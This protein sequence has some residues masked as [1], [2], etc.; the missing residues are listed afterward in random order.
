[1]KS[2]NLINKKF[3]KL[4]VI[5]LNEERTNKCN[6]MAAYW[7]CVCDCGNT[8]VVR[9]SCLRSGNSKSCGCNKHRLGKNNPNFTG[10]QEIGGRYWKELKKQAVNKRKLIFNISIRYAWNLFLK[11]NRKCALTDMELKFPLR[12]NDYSRTASLDR[13]DSSKGYVKGNV[14]WVHRDINY[15]KQNYS[16]D[17][18]IELCEK[19]ITH[20]N[21]T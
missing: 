2:I 12:D 21:R 7:N 6:R 17:Y 13:I 10:Y 20:K 15:M 1:M 5:S 14:Q 3:G 4:K 8:C 11:Q 9:G 18:F 16:Q 19:V